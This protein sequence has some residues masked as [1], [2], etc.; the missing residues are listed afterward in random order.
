VLVLSTITVRKTEI[1][2]DSNY[3]EVFPEKP[4]LTGNY[5]IL[6]EMVIVITCQSDLGW[7]DGITYTLLD[8]TAYQN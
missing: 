6:G 1:V 7:T 5:Q 8:S 2:T 4:R 3:N